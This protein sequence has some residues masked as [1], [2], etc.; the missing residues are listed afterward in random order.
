M[1]AIQ[2]KNTNDI[3]VDSIGEKTGASGLTLVN[4]T[5]ALTTLFTNTITERSVSNGVDIESVNL[6]NGFMELINFAAPGNPGVAGWRVYSDSADTELKAR[7]NSGEVVNISELPVLYD[8]D[9]GITDSSSNTTLRTIATV[10]ITAE[11]DELILAFGE[12]QCSNTNSAG[13]VSG[14]TSISAVGGKRIFATPAEASSNG[15]RQTVNPM[16]IRTGLS[17]A[18]ACILQFA[19]ANAGVA[20]TSQ[21][22]LH[23]LQ[24]KFRS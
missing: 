16:H 14:Q 2:P 7:D 3:L 6:Q 13:Q 20:H 23:V 19:Q 17:G 9:N 10:N 24:F 8:F 11:A 21:S 15:Q 18:V 12:L 1:A 5:T 4:D 22:R